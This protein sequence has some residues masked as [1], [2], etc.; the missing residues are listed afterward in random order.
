MSRM[1]FVFG[2]SFAILASTVMLIFLLMDVVS[3]DLFGEVVTRAQGIVAV[4]TLASL[5][6][7]GLRKLVK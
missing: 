1:V 7:V 6:L 3:L 5:A 2:A 4:V